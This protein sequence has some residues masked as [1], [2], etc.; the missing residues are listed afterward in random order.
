MAKYK[1]TLFLIGIALFSMFITSCNSNRNNIN[2]TTINSQSDSK[3]DELTTE[4][5]INIATDLFDE[6]INQNRTDWKIV[7][8]DHLERQP[9]V[10]LTDYKIHDVLFVSEKDNTLTFDISFDIQYTNESNYWLAGTGTISDNNWI[11]NKSTFV[12]IKKYDDK[13]FI[14]NIYT[15]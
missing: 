11:I 10:C 1:I 8:Y 7:K 4:Q 3:L 13:Y 15:G 2:S 12:D 9:V 5:K 6:Y 14:T